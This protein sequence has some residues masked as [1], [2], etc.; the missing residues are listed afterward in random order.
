M[1][2]KKETIPRVAS[3]RDRDGERWKGGREERRVEN[4][5]SRERDKVSRAPGGGQPPTES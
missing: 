3:D 1:R 2:E 4:V 5:R